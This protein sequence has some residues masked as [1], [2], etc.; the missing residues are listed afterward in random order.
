MRPHIPIAPANLDVFVVPRTDQ[1]LLYLVLAGL[2]LLIALRFMKPAFAPVGV[3]ARA[4]A[5]AA[6][7]AVSIGL[8]LILVT[9]AAF[10]AG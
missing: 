7:V 5:A 4:V 2:F 10:S 1:P 8:A 9:G 6:V 3:L